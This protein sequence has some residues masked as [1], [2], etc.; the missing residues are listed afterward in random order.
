MNPK[1]RYLF[2]SV[3]AIGLILL[4]YQI[5]SNLPEIDPVRIL[6]IAVPDMLFVFLAYKTYPPE[7]DAKS[8]HR[9]SERKVSNY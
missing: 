5:I 7:A 6:L 8:S 9:Y 3:G 2:L 4:C 1:Y